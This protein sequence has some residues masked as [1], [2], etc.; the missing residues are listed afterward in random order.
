MS[1]ICPSPETCALLDTLLAAVSEC[2]VLF[3]T[4]G[5]LLRTS[6]SFATLLEVEN[7][8]LKGKNLYD[9]L[10]KESG[11]Q[12]RST[13]ETAVPNVPCNVQIWL[14][15]AEGQQ[16]KTV[17]HLV[18]NA[19]GKDAVA[20]LFLNDKA[21]SKERLDLRLISDAFMAAANAIVICDADARILKVNPAFSKFTGYSANEAV[22]QST[23]LLRSGEHDDSF[24]TNL[25]QTVLRG[26]VWQGE[27]VNKRKDG[28]LYTEDMT[29][30]PVFSEEGKVEYYIAIKQ[31]I[32]ERKKLEDMYLRSQRM[33]SIGAIA[34]GVAHDLN[35]VLSPII[36][37]ADLL[38]AKCEDPELLELYRMIKD[39]AKD[40][41]NIVKQ[42]LGFARGDGSEFGILQVRHLLKDLIHIFRST[43]P[44][45]ITINSQLCRDLHPARGNATRLNQAFT[46]VMINARDAMPEGGTLL[47][48]AVNQTLDEHFVAQNPE[49]HTGEFLRVRIQD[50][51]TGMTPEVKE[52][53]FE[54]FF[55]TKEKGKGTGLGLPTTLSII[56]E[57]GG[58]LLLESSPGEGTVIDMFLQAAAPSERV[59]RPEVP[60]FAETGNQE[61]ILVVDDEESIRYMLNS[62][63]TVLGYQ[64]QS[65]GDGQEAVEWVKENPDKG[66]LLLLDMMMP[67]VDGAEVYQTLKEAGLLPPTL[68]MSG[69]VPESLFASTDLDIDQHFIAKPFSI[70]T[71]SEKIK[72]IL[73]A[74]HG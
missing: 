60:S 50:E 5:D 42:L 17:G 9:F 23:S 67:E 33:E 7:H 56:K 4:S 14:I 71:L 48:E 70:Q 32:T 72:A 74:Q 61:L 40:G 73:T 21:T 34:S 38:I 53:I 26:E 8:E 65:L 13:L 18:R 25:W 39:G 51:G 69:M 52:K 37:S 35:N 41:G 11:E 63:L 57:H 30:T 22:G 28:S 19:A 36:M 1:P 27:I 46:N 62:T 54:S 47:V 58:F 49:A 6:E 64:V 16:V 24:Y 66:D 20:T 45:N 43:F 44:K 3:S 68:V 12:V 2:V 31:D 10:K 55:T 59:S 15:N 29:I